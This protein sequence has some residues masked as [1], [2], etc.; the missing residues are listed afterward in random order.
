MAETKGI[1]LDFYGN[2]VEFE[3]TLDDVNKGLKGTKDELNSINKQLKINPKGLDALEEKLKV[4]KNQQ[5]LLSEKVSIYKEELS[6]LG[7]EDIG[8]DKW[9]A[10]TSDLEKAQIQYEKVSKSIGYVTKDING[11][12]NVADETKKIGDNAKESETRVIDL[13][14]IIKANLIS[15]AIISGVK[16]L[17]SE[18]KQ[19]A[20]ELNR[21]ADSYRELQVYEKQFENN[22]RNTADA[23]DEEID[24]L[25]KLAK[26]KQKQGVI[27]ARA[28]TSGYQELATYVESTD[29]IVMLTD[30]LT[31]MSAQQYGVNATDESVRNLATT[32]GKA[33]ANGD[34]SGLT[35]LGY[36]FTDAQKYIMEYGNEL[37]RAKVIADIVNE[38]I[39]GMN[40][41]LAQTDAG[42]IFQYQQYFD[43]IK[44]SVGGLVSELQLQLLDG[45][46]PKIQEIVENIVGWLYDHKD[47]LVQMVED[48]VTWLTSDDFAEFFEDV[49]NVVIDIGNILK[50]V[51]EILDKTG[52]LKGAWEL[53]KTA[54]QGVADIVHAIRDDI[55]YISTHGIGDWAMGNYNSYDFGSGGDSWT[56]G[57]SGGYGALNSG[58]YA[59]TM[60]PVFNI[61]SNNITRADVR[62]WSDWILDDINE[63]LGRAF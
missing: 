10:L 53:F 48:I 61:Y 24:A 17:G 40:E 28:I 52:L 13:G 1:T 5:T 50:D 43:G 4:L 54:V 41:T 14:D 34:Y 62:S 63:G 35:R 46:M 49:S 15:Q 32:L 58:G 57:W 59:F 25:K 47:E 31:D 16:K 60:N 56:P 29:A 33:L 23:S 42:K 27:S 51:V 38:S 9:N 11:I 7:K 12:K 6:K 39:G 21:W 37:Q 2:A 55:E 20:S 30:A 26:Q 8:S 36:G 45:V 18:I 19:M 44:E 22:I 3:K